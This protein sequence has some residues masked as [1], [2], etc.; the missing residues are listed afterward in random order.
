MITLFLVEFN[1]KVVVFVICRMHGQ[2]EGY[3]GE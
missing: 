1:L 2:S 3:C